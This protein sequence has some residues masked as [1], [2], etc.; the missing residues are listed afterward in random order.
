MTQNNPL[1]HASSPLSD[2][3][4]RFALRCTPR[5]WVMASV[6]QA[7]HCMR[8]DRC[9]WEASPN[10]GHTYCPNLPVPHPTSSNTA[11]THRPSQ[12]PLVLATLGAVLQ[13]GDAPQAIHCLEWLTAIAGESASFFD[14][15]L[16]PSTQP[17]TPLHSGNPCYASQPG[18]AIL[19]FLPPVILIPHHPSQHYALSTSQ[20]I[21]SACSAPSISHITLL[22][23]VPVIP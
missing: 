4:S 2:G 10:N 8:T 7:V 14:K 17:L 16:L 5:S 12:V 6:W 23:T 1:A 13:A 21:P 15:A 11:T 22:T 18:A 20:V 9:V 19:S 3:P